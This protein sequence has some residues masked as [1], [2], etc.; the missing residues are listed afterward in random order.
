MH[1]RALNSAQ[2]GHQC[3]PRHSGGRVGH[4]L[5]RRNLFVDLTLVPDALRIM[6]RSHP[7]VRVQIHDM[8]VTQQIDALREG[9]IDVGLVRGPIS[10]PD[11]VTETL[12]TEPFVVAVPGDHPLA[13]KR[14][15]TTKDVSQYPFIATET[16]NVTPNLG[17]L[18]LSMFSD[19]PSLD[20]RHRVTEMNTLIALVRAGM[21]ISIVPASLQNIRISDVSLPAVVVADTSKQRRLHGL[22]PPC[23]HK[24]LGAV[25]QRCSTGRQEWRALASRGRVMACMG[26][27][28]VVS[29]VRRH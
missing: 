26:R 14:R 2:E 18:V 11:V 8:T 4:Y 21:G 29:S 15:I 12:F 27:S 19:H 25:C 16:P 9:R 28:G 7:R 5:D 20:I 10:S 6:E 13:H 3:R 1:K 17:S 23:R 22:A 24:N